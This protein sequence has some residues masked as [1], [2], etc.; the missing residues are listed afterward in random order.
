MWELFEK[1]MKEITD[2]RRFIEEALVETGLAAMFFA[3]SRVVKLCV[4]QSMSLNWSE[5][6][7]Q[8]ELLVLSL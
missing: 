1:K 7:E 8:I 5:V 6:Y 3:F 2:V 4:K